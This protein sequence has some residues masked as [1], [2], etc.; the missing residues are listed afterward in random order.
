MYYNITIC[1]FG[2]EVAETVKLNFQVY[3]D[4]SNVENVRII[5][6]EGTYK[7]IEI[8]KKYFWLHF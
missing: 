2:I 4:N 1:R 6:K 8:L 5:I 3:Q 7:N